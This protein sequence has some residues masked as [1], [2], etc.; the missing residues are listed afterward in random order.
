M[1]RRRQP[2]TVYPKKVTKKNGKK[3]VTYYYS[4]NPECGLPENVCA[5]EQ[6]KSTGQRTKGAAVEW[7]LTE[8]IP[9][10]KEQAEHVECPKVTL[11]QFL[12]PYFLYDSCPH[13]QRLV[14]DRKAPTQRYIWDQR[15]RIERLVFDDEI[16]S[17]DVHELRP[18]HFEDWKARCAS[19]LKEESTQRLYGDR[20]INQTL[21]ALKICFN[22]GIHRGEIDFNPVQLVGKI[23][24]EPEDFGIYS[25]D[26]LRRI[27]ILE[28]EVWFYSEEYLGNQNAAPDN[29]LVLTHAMLFATTGERPGSL[30]KLRWDDF[31][32]DRLNL[33]SDILKIRASRYIPLIPAVQKLL[34]DQK[35]VAQFTS[36]DDFIFA[37][38]QTGEELS[39]TWY[40]NSWERMMKQSELPVLDPDGRRRVPYSFKHSLITHLI[41]NGADELLVAQLVGHSAASG[42]TRRLTRVQERYK[43]RQYETLVARL[44]PY[45]L[46][47]FL[48]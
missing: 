9:E 26:E 40:R 33:R 27:F 31:L 19:A 15:R 45:V 8:R 32:G 7:V 17:I 22:E 38:N 34:A 20:T 2:F 39:Y 43:S 3:S 13:V 47:I 25:I 42:I 14:T 37:N 41:D 29:L 18:G 36:E 23:R 10:L 30:L 12:E 28:P 24:E 5:G 1:A 11:R 46:K 44:V 48:T 21:T 16:S 4:L 6:R 35:S